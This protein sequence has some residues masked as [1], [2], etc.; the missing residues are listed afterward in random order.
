MEHYIYTVKLKYIP[1]MHG[2]IYIINMQ[3]NIQK[4][5]YIR[6]MFM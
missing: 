5:Q 4:E 2:S 1:F 6:T 3:S